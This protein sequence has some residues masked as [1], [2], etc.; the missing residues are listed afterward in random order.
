MSKICAYPTPFQ[1]LICNGLAA[2]P[3]KQ[4]HH[5]KASS[6]STVRNVPSSGEHVGEP[7]HH[8]IGGAHRNSAQSS[9]SSSKSISGH[10][11]HGRSGFTESVVTSRGRSSAK[12]AAKLSPP[13]AEEAEKW[14]V[15]GAG[16]KMTTRPN[17]V[18]GNRKERAGGGDEYRRTSE[19]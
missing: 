16:V 6:G 14:M 12:A 17:G 8:S 15:Q 13:A 9:S 19:H 7:N 5:H 4:S 1:Q 3:P 2:A 18:H 10:L 11:V